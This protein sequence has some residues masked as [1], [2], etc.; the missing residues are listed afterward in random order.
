VNSAEFEILIDTE[1]AKKT[2][3]EKEILAIYKQY[4]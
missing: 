4:E 1:K 3:I 2:D